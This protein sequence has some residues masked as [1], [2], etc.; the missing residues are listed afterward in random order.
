M[1]TAEF[2]VF[3]DA[4]ALPYATRV[5]FT[6]GGTAK[7]KTDYTGINLKPSVNSQ[8]F[9]AANDG[10]RYSAGGQAAQRGGAD[11]VCGYSCGQTDRRCADHAD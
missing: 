7:L 11:W 10:E 3:R 2:E 1:D 6:V 5:Y 8:A 4:A 9:V